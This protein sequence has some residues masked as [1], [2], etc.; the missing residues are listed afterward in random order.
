MSGY[1][2]QIQFQELQMS[3]SEL[4]LDLFSWTTKIILSRSYIEWS[5]K[6]RKTHVIRLVAAPKLTKRE[7]L[8]WNASERFYVSQGRSGGSDGKEPAYNAKDLCSIPASG[9]Y[10]GEG[11]GNPLQYSCLENS[12]DRGTSQISAMEEQR[13]RHGWATN[14]FTSK[15]IQNIKKR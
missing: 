10:P 3:V 7:M 14:T 2:G 5:E 1:R 12:K 15:H 9:R 8:F 4:L 6:Y 11:H 13:V